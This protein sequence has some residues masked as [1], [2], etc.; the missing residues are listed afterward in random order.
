MPHCRP[1]SRQAG[2]GYAQIR[3]ELSTA[4]LA[5]MQRNMSAELVY[6]E[7]WPG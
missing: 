7:K 6:A 4:A 5:M 2:N 3:P 1:R